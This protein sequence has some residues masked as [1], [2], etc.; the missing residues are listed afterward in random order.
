MGAFALAVL[1]AIAVLLSM[2][3]P[4]SAPSPQ[5]APLGFPEYAP[6]PRTADA[7]SAQKGFNALVSFTDNGFEPSTITIEKGETIRFSNNASTDLK[8]TSS[9]N[10]FFV[11]AGS[12]ASRNYVEITFSQS[13]QFQYLDTTTRGSGTIIVQ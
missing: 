12:I 11:G 5:S 8:L 6:A 13:G 1:A 10:T 9:D 2:S 3:V 4:R 7:V